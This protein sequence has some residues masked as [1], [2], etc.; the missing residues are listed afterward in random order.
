[1]RARGGMTSRS[2]PNRSVSSLRDTVKMRPDHGLIHSRKIV[3]LIINQPNAIKAVSAAVVSDSK[4]SAHVFLS[5]DAAT[6]NF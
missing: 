3:S 2:I 5:I 6:W 1:M 4:F